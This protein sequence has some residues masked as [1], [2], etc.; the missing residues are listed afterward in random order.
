MRM[1]G[2]VMGAFST[3]AT[4]RSVILRSE[5]IELRWTFAGAASRSASLSRPNAEAPAAALPMEVKNDRR[6]GRRT[7]AGFMRPPFGPI[8]GL[9]EHG[10]HRQAGARPG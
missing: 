5:G 8:A 3:T 6:S 7:T 4:R 2:Q 10:W 9:E 1:S